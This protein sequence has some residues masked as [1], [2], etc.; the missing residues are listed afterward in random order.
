MILKWFLPVFLLMG[1]A[2]I[3]GEY[4]PPVVEVSHFSGDSTLLL[5][6]LPQGGEVT[7]RV[8]DTCPDFFDY[9]IFQERISPG[10]AALMAAPMPAPMPASPYQ[11]ETFLKD[12]KIACVISPSRIF[13]KTIDRKND[14]ELYLVSIK[15]KPSFPKVIAAKLKISRAELDKSAGEII[16]TGKTD[17]DKKA[18]LIE[19]YQQSLDTKELQDSYVMIPIGWR[20]RF[21]AYDMNYLLYPQF[22]QNDNHSFEAQLSVKYLFYDSEFTDRAPSP[23]RTT[24][25]FAYTGKF[26]FYVGSRKSSPVISRTFNPAFHVRHSYDLDEKVFHWWDLSAQ[27]RSNGQAVT[28]TALTADHKNDQHYLDGISR[29]ANYGQLMYGLGSDMWKLDFSGKVYVNGGESE[30]TWGKYAGTKTNFAD[31]DIFRVKGS[32]SFATGKKGCTDPGLGFEYVIGE[33]GFGGHS[34][35]VFATWPVRF[36]PGGWELPLLVKAHFGPMDRL[37]DYSTS[38]SSVGVGFAFTY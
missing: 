9:S 20:Q 25:F 15:K 1:S 26:D 2:A 16:A 10:P 23:K 27:H 34:V 38:M 4:R 14:E 7:V 33:K 8:Y 31:F 35:D 21:K 18:K 32:M 22:T 30:I 12:N 24:F 37:S 28:A 36:W 6:D 5:R 17:E 3:A 29:S 19:F 13:E 11:F